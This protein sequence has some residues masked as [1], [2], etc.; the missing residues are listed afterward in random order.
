M[1]W[2]LAEKAW[3]LPMRCSGRT[4]SPETAAYRTI[5]K[6]MPQV[7]GPRARL[8]R[9]PCIAVSVM[10]ISRFAEVLSASCKLVT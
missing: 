9:S 5:G 10:S 8:Q 4:D 2:D 7:G 3:P 1:S 6:S